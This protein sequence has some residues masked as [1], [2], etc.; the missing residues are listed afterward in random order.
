MN[1]I[2]DAFPLLAARGSGLESVTALLSETVTGHTWLVNR[3]LIKTNHSV[4]PWH[5]P[6]FKC[7]AEDCCQ[8]CTEL[9]WPVPAQRHE[10]EKEAGGAQYTRCGQPYRHSD[11]RQPLAQAT[12][13]EEEAAS[14]ERAVLA[15]AQGQEKERSTACLPA[16]PGQPRRGF[17][18]GVG[19]FLVKGGGASSKKPGTQQDSQGHGNCRRVLLGRQCGSPALGEAASYQ[20][21]CP[22]VALPAGRPCCRVS[23][24]GIPT[25]G[26][27]EAG[28]RPFL[29]IPFV[30]KSSEYLV[31]Q[32]AI[33]QQ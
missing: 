16:V 6:R 10:T 23:G 14:S 18:P 28:T 15:F 7:T 22:G 8:H 33:Y 30:C 32:N 12:A 13:A 19:W 9:S 31:L 20:C 2:H 24:C 26:Q 1:V 21:L 11:R 25:Q 5:Q 4:S 27:E 3:K 17:T 29:H